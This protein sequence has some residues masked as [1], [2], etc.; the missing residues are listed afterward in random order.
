MRPLGVALILTSVLLGGGGLAFRLVGDA[1]ASESAEPAAGSTPAAQASEAV[2][3]PREPGSVVIDLG[4]LEDGSRSADVVPLNT[5]G[6]NHARAPE[7][8]PAPPAAPDR[9]A[10]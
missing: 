6:Y 3:R 10:R 7:P 1:R 2:C 5:R 4:R 8:R 9:F